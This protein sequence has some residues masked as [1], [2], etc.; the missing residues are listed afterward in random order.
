MNHGGTVASGRHT[1]RTS[2]GGGEVSFPKREL[3]P[4]GAKRLRG[5]HRIYKSRGVEGPSS[6]TA[7]IG[8]TR[9]RRVF[10]QSNKQPALKRSK[11]LLAKSAVFLGVAH[12]CSR[13]A[14]WPLLSSR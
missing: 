12:L 11:Q 7:V 10:P 14:P 3:A 6:A 5:A 8:H 1:G 13:Q 4:Q 9:A 2:E